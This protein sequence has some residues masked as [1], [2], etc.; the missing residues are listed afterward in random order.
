MKSIICPHHLVIQPEKSTTK[1]RIVYNTSS[2]IDGPS[3]NQ[4]LETGPNLLPKLIDILI[5]LRSYKVALISDIKQAF[6]NVSVKE[7]DRDFLR[8]LWIKDTNSDNIEIIGRC[9]ARVTFGTTA[10]QFLW[11]VSIHKYLLTSKN[12]DQNFVEKFLANLYVDDNINRDDSYEKAFE[13]YKKSV[14]T[15]ER[16]RFRVEKISH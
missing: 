13:L 14:G 3:L 15:Y 12:V 5:R 10:S 7:S 16:C 2:S 1:L 11:A 8:F 6:L 9:F 4:C